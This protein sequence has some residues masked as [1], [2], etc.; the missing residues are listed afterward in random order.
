MKDNEWNDQFAK[1]HEL[2]RS[3]IRNL[4]GDEPA[5]CNSC[6]RVHFAGD[7]IED[8]GK[9]LSGQVTTKE[10]KEDD[11]D[12]PTLTDYD[13]EEEKE[14]IDDDDAQMEAE[15]QLRRS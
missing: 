1:A 10:A 13:H 15:V 11:D 2:R 8:I 14:D 3:F 4:R 7:D 5:P 6:P 12:D 9:H